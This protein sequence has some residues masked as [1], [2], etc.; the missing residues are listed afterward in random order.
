MKTLLFA[1]SLLPLAMFAFS[2]QPQPTSLTDVQKA[3]IE[4]SAK[5]VVNAVIAN[6]NKLDFNAY[7]QFYSADADGRYIE[8]GSMS[9]SL[10]EMKKGYIDLAP[11]LE[12]LQNTVDA[13]DVLVLGPDA[14]SLTVPFHFSFKPKGHPEYKAQGVFSVI[15]QRRAGSWKI[16]QSHESWVNPEQVM[17]ALVPPATK[18]QVAKRKQH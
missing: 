3:A 10:D 8:N 14:A 6:A 17:A 4:D 15:V 5:A 12:S 11:T 1:V 18:Q 16:V 2:C 9:P 13:I 7:F